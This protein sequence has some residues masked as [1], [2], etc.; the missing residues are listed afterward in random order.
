MK[1]IAFLAAAACVALATPAMAQTSAT[2]TVNVTG[3]VAA[4]CTAITPITGTIQLNELALANGTV[5]TAFSSTTGG[6]PGLTKTFTV[7]CTSAAPTITVSATSLDHSTTAASTGGYTGRVHYK[8]TLAADT[9]ASTTVSAVYTTADTPP[10][11]VS[12]PLGGPLANATGNVRITVSNGATTNSGDLLRA[13]T[14][15]VNGV[16][17]ITVSPT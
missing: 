5:D 6:T 14:Y 3:S 4:K 12:T 13:G 2:G 11:A 7:K 15:N 8:A 17:T 16:I 1:K 10:A 9:A